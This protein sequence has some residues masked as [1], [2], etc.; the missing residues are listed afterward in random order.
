[1]PRAASLAEKLLNQY[2]NQIGEVAL[3]P[4]AG[5]AFEVNLDGEKVYSKLET[6]TFPNERALLGQMGPKL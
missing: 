6:G 3:V 2:K 5:G 1:L 4:S